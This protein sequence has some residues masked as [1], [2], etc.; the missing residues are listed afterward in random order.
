VA[1]PYHAGDYLVRII[2]D[3]EGDKGQVIAH[4]RLME[5]VFRDRELRTLYVNCISWMKHYLYDR[6]A[7]FDVF[8]T[9]EAQL[10]LL[11]YV[12]QVSS[13]EGNLA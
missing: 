2:F 11:T 7:R 9:Y 8:S 13:T 1:D 4:H 6:Y 3:P 5:G 12:D 10:M